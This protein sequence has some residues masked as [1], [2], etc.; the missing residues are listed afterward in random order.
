MGELLKES[1]PCGGTL[2]IWRTEWEVSY[3]FPGPDRRY[4]GTIVTLKGP[5]LDS[6]IEAYKENWLE[7]VNLKDSI[8]NGGT[9]LNKTGKM[10]M[11]ICT[12]GVYLRGHHVLVSTPKQLE[13]IINSY[14][15]AI[16]R[17]TQ[18]QE[19]AQLAEPCRVIPDINLSGI[20]T[21]QNVSMDETDKNIGGD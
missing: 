16:K 11:L 13:N 20:E 6:Y 8:S 5:S 19:A 9:F 7:Y 17:A 21:T 4:R 12:E 10:G 3:Y 14:Q 2:H 18:V 15:Y 1:L